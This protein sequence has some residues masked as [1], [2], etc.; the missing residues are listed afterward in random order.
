L[1]AAAVGVR[2]VTPEVTPGV[3]AFGG[4]VTLDRV[5]VVTAATPAVVIV[6]V[7]VIHAATEVTPG[8]TAFGGVVTLD[9]IRVVLAVVVSE[10]IIAP[11]TDRRV[12]RT[13]TV[14]IDTRV[15]GIY[16]VAGCWIPI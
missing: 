11:P 5:R 9:R 15:A 7:I 14:G 3:T 8:V 12:A 10:S 4:V 1:G 16:W 13:I 6:I 2:D